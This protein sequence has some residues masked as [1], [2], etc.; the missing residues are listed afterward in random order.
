MQI[1]GDNVLKNEKTLGAEARNAVKHAEKLFNKHDKIITRIHPAIVRVGEK[2]QVGRELYEYDNN[3]F[4]DWIT[5]NRLDRGRI[6]G[7]QQ[8]RTAAM[9]IYRLVVH[10]YAED[11]KNAIPVKL[12]LTNCHRARPTDIIDWA[13]KD[14]PL[15]FDDLRKKL[16]A[17]LSGQGEKKPADKDEA[18]FESDKI[19]DLGVGES[20]GD[21]GA[22]ESPSIGDLKTALAAALEKI[23]KLEAK[24]R[25]LGADPDKEAAAGDS[26]A[27]A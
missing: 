19:G 1:A 11:V 26:S 2:L 25:E 16:A 20:V 4:N 27:G 7:R 15:L 13:R 22:G 24:L 21:L 18:D 17:Q 8:E 23:R 6:F 9:T 12:D 14:Q 5:R 3:G 10:G